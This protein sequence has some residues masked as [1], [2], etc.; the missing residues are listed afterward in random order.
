MLAYLCMDA[1]PISLSVVIRRCVQ[2]HKGSYIDQ[3]RHVLLA[4][5]Q[6]SANLVS[7]FKG[8]ALNTGTSV[9]FDKNYVFSH[10][11]RAKGSPFVTWPPAE[12][13]QLSVTD[14]T[15]WQLHG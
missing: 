1:S 8:E 11:T 5:L 7:F 14:V 13:C 12:W 9:M 2:M 6:N 15:W 10:I 3:F 4:V